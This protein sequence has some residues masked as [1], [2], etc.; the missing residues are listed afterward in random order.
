[1]GQVV[2]GES[3]TQERARKEPSYYKILLQEEKYL[4]K[5]YEWSAF[6]EWSGGRITVTRCKYVARE[7]C[8]A[9]YVSL[10]E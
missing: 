7:R 5:R 1:M 4:H 2:V 6:G 9:L 10:L 3:L 8:G